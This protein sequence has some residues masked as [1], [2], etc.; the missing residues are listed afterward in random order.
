LGSSTPAILQGNPV[1]QVYY[2][3]GQPPGMVQ[4]FHAQPIETILAPQIEPVQ[5]SSP[6]PQQPAV[7][8]RQGLVSWHA[9]A[10]VNRWVVTGLAKK[11]CLNRSGRYRFSH[12]VG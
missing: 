7:W 8:T 4:E 6:Q 5:H 10:G 3:L 2:P 1:E 12:Q 11:A 9:N